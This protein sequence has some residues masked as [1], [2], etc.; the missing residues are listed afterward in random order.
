[1]QHAISYDYF[2][3]KW[4]PFSDIQKKL[5]LLLE[6]QTSYLTGRKFIELS[7]ST[8]HYFLKIKATSLIGQTE[9]YDMAKP[10][11][12][13]LIMNKL[14]SDFIENFESEIFNDALKNELVT[15]INKK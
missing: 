4:I 11:I 8:K 3:D 6:D 1:M 13:S 10:K 7:D 2:S 14:K 9:P 12:A 15:F 5:P